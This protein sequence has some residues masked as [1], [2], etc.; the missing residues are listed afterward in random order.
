MSEDKSSKT[1]QATPKKLRDA[2]KKGQ[3]P[4]SKDVVSFTILV[5]LILYFIF[6]WDSIEDDLKTLILLPKEVLLLDFDTATF[7]LAKKIGSL[8][9][10]GILLPISLLTIVGGILGN[11]FQVGFIFS[12]DPVSPKLSKLN[13]IAGFKRIFSIKQLKTTFISLLKIIAISIVFYFVFYE[14]LSQAI[15]DL[16]ICGIEC[17]KIILGIFVKKM[18]ISILMI[19]LITTVIDIIIQKTEFQKEQKMSKEDIKRERKNMDGDPMVKSELRRLRREVANDDVKQKIK[20]SR[21][22]I[23]SSGVSIV[24][25]YEAGVT[26]LP[27]ITSI[28][29]AKMADKM[30]EIARAE[31]ISMHESFKLVQLILSKGSVDQYIPEES[32]E[33]VAFALRK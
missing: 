33:G 5:L 12:W 23:Y 26:P 19:L 7:I 32:I 27:I 15:F 25:K 10:F 3:V 8:A 28:G 29:K 18:I 14:F 13:P 30:L 11:V 4:K 1:E 21:V 24:L 17:Q 9:L 16:S 20:D 31:K 22:L 2:R 6:F